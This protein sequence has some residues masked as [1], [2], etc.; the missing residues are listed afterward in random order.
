MTSNSNVSL[1]N[2]NHTNN[3]VAQQ[4][5]SRRGCRMPR[6]SCGGL[7]KASLVVGAIIAPIM[8][9]AMH[10]RNSPEHSNPV[11]VIPTTYSNSML[12]RY[13][14]GICTQQPSLFGET[15]T[16]VGF[17][18]RFDFQLNSSIPSSLLSS[19]SV[20][21]IDIQDSPQLVQPTPLALPAPEASNDSFPAQTTTAVVSLPRQPQ[22]TPL[23]NP[24]VQPGFILTGESPVST[25]ATPSADQRPGMLNRA[26]HFGAR[27]VGTVASN[28]LHSCGNAASRLASH[29]TPSAIVS[30]IGNGVNNQIIKPLTRLNNLRQSL[31]HFQQTPQ[32]VATSVADGVA[33]VSNAVDSY[34]VQPVVN[35]YNGVTYAANAIAEGTDSYVVQPAVATYNAAVTVKNIAGYTWS[36]I[37]APYD[38][39]FWVQNRFSQ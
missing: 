1:S 5:T 18:N 26:L 7:I 9:G 20:R 36:A 17:P 38:A 27:A 28:V 4:G 35:T 13:D 33:N 23:P 34:V 16:T 12:S 39:L 19:H 24:V 21:I 6:F 2:V 31:L 11:A 25:P 29:F 3:V 8:A 32:R 14:D 37:R 10:L 15:N 22:N 30:S